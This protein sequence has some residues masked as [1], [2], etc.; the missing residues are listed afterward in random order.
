MLQFSSNQYIN[1][2]LSVANLNDYAN[3][4]SASNGANVVLITDACHSD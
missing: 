4:L 1:F 2:A 3:T